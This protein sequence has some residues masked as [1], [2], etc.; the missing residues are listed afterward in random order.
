VD[1]YRRKIGLKP[2]VQDEIRTAWKNS[3]AK[4]KTL[5]YK[6]RKGLF[7][8]DPAAE[9]KGNAAC[10]KVR[11][12]SENPAGEREAIDDLEAMG[13]DGVVAA[14]NFLTADIDWKTEAGKM[15]GTILYDM[16]QRKARELWG[17]EIEF[18]VG[19]FESNEEI[20]TAI[21]EMKLKI[22]EKDKAYKIKE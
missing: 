5:R 2:L 14:L 9:S 6:V 16:I 13:K 11:E 20:W 10:I 19:A 12:S 8:L 22:L 15:T 21:T 18:T 7:A 1:E 4:A 17:I 3:D